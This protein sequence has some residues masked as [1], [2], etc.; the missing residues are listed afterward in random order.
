MMHIDYR[1]PADA[2]RLSLADESID[3]FI[4]FGVLQHVPREPTTAILREGRRVLNRSGRMVHTANTCDH[5]SHVDRS[6]SPIW[7][8]REPE[9][10]D[11]DGAVAG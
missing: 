3:V 9:R 7:Q 6:V 10:D 2:S 5:F 8:G 4:S 11:A 1:A